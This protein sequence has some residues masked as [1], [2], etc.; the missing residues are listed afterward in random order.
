M[1]D[2]D[3]R[4]LLKQ[5]DKYTRYSRACDTARVKIRLGEKPAMSGGILGFF[6][7]E[8]GYPDLTFTA[9]ETSA[10]YEALYVAEKTFDDRVK[11]FEERVKV[12]EP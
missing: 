7:R 12:V 10:I 5:A 9:E 1:S 3:A 11:Q 2:L 4:E 6:R 8:K